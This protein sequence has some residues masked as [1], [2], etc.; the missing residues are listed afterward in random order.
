LA[1]EIR[2]FYP[3]PIVLSAAAMMLFKGGKKSRTRKV[4]RS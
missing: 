3:I 1:I 2:L 4:R